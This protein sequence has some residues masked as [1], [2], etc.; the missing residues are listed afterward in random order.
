MLNMRASIACRARWVYN[1]N[2]CLCKVHVFKLALMYSLE[3]RLCDDR[4]SCDRRLLTR[5]ELVH[6]DRMIVTV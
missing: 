4:K 1:G 6:R 3:S 2:G 5:L